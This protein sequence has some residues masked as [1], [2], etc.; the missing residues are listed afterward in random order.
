MNCHC[1]LVYTVLGV[2]LGEMWF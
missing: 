1:S 2:M